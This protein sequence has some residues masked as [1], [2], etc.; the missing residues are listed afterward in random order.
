MKA[1]LLFVTMGM[2]VMRTGAQVSAGP[3]LRFVGFQLILPWRLVYY[4]SCPFG[5]PPGTVATVTAS[6]PGVVSMAIN[7]VFA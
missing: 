3:R 1:F 5:L 7:T 4:E 2:V 6:P